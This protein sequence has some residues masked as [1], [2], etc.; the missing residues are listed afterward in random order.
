MIVRSLSLMRRRGTFDSLS[1]GAIA[2][3]ATSRKP[4]STSVATANLGLTKQWILL[5]TW[6]MHPHQVPGASALTGMF[7]VDV[8]LML[9][10]GSLQHPNPFHKSGSVI[11]KDS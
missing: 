8:Q 6:A 2:A 10:R 4:F 9:P 5:R 7:V 1:L 11:A 3:T